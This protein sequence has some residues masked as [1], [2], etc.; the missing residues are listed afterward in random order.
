[1]FLEPT[2]WESSLKDNYVY[3]IVTLTDVMVRRIVSKVKRE[4]TIVLI[5]DNE[6]FKS[7]K[8]KTK[9]V[10]EIWY[11]RSKISPFLHSPKFVQEAVKNE[12]ETLRK[13]VQKQS[14]QIDQLHFKINQIID[15]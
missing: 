11:V 10:K 14:L 6:Y 2:L 4:K 3:V 9:E 12:L 1:S 8:L 5:S 15:R 7:I 13:H